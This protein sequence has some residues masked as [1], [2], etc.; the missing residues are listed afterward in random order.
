MSANECIEEPLSHAVM[1]DFDGKAVPVELHVKFS[2]NVP[3]TGKAK[4]KK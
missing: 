1:R 3:T 4:T 2:D